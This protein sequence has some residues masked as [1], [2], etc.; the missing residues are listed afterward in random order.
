MK[1]KDKHCVIC[2]SVYY[3]MNSLQKTCSMKCAIEYANVKTK[4]NAV[5]EARKR[6]KQLENEWDVMTPSQW[7]AKLQETFNKYIR[8]R[9]REKGCVS[10]GIPL[11]NRKFDAG[12]FYATTY[13]GLR[14]HEWNVHGQCVQ[15]NQH[16]HSNPHEYRRRITN[17]ITPDQLQWLD[18]NRYTPLKLT[19]PEMKKMIDTYKQ[20]IKEHGN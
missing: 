5:K 11:N 7:K 8:L 13:E 10:C 6:K 20:K 14:F 4:E 16:E 15:C 19:I 3:P 1:V 17:R 12:H 9:D 18:D 2:N